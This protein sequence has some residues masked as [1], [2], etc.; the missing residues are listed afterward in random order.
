MAMKMH[1]E[2]PLQCKCN[3]P[4]FASILNDISMM[5]MMGVLDFLMEVGWSGQFVL[6]PI[7]FLMFT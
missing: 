4:H 6:S 2:T 7:V 1:V 5:F 3:S